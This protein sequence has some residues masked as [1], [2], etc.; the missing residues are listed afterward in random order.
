MSEQEKVIGHFRRSKWTGGFWWRTLVTLGL[1]WLILWRRNQLTL[2]TRR[3]IERRGNILGGEEI[4]VNLSRITDIR[5]KTSALGSILKYGLFEVQSAGSDQAEI[6][7]A[8][9]AQPHRLKDQIYD[10]QDGKLDGN[11]AMSAQVAET[12][13]PGAEE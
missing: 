11:N 10:L 7:F 13:K 3:L 1:Y 9:L 4:S 6:S 8:G 2:T 5:V 12:E